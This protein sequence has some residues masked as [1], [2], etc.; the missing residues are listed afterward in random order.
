MI[1]P[2]TP[3]ILGSRSPRR[4]EILAGLG[5][6]F[7]V[8][9]AEIDE[10][11][12]SAESV[13][14]YIERVVDDKARA[15]AELLGRREHGV[16]L[17]ADTLVTVDGL[18]LGKPGS[19]EGAVAMLERL[20]GRSHTVLTRYRVDTAAGLS[21]ARTVR[22]QVHFRGASRSELEAYARSGEGLDKAGAYAIQ[23][24]GAFLVERLDGSY[25]AVV[26]LPA[27]ELVA[28]LLALGAL[29]RFPL[30]PR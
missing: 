17:V 28:D 24:L 13:D 1:G 25:T 5:V 22:S 30:P 2:E 16:R 9:A 27:C 12:N 19:E 11:P 18:I 4:A 7:E 26:G 8:V 21:L 23:G 14:G 15:T 10:T 6:P 20:C 29:S 3:L